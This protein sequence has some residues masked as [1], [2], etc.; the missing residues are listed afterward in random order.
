MARTDNTYLDELAVHLRLAGMT[1]DEIGAV[2]EEA[3]D[4]IQESGE[5]ARTAFGSPEEYAEA[6][7][8]SHGTRSASLINMTRA[9]LIAAAAQIGAWGLLVYSTVALSSPG[10]VAIRPGYLV[11]WLILTVG[12]AWPVWPIVRS[13]AVRKT[14]F[15][16]TMLVMTLV[17]GAAVVPAVTWEEPVLA[18]IP[19]VPGIVAAVVV[20]G[21][22]WLRAWRLRDP[23]RRPTT[24]S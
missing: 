2:L 16:P 5:P 19:A 18:N 1:G 20:I 7:A 9:D 11:G 12:L 24:T 22:C 3:R 14:G 4:H 8:L 13:F 21:A 10:G 15:L 23:I 6:L 17:V